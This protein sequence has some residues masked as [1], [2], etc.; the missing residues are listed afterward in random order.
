MGLFSPVRIQDFRYLWVGKIF[1]ELGDWAARLALAALVYE[2]TGSAA[3]TGLVT[4]TIV[5]PWVF[6]PFLVGA[7]A[8]LPYRR[9]MLLTDGIR[10]TAFV[11]LAVGLP[12]PWMIAILLLASLTTPIFDASQAAVIREAVRDDSLYLQARTL[13]HLSSQ[14][15]QLVGLSLGGLLLVLIGPTGALLFNAGTF[16][17]TLVC[18]S[19]LQC[20]RQSNP[21]HGSAVATA[22]LGGRVIMS[23]PYLWRVASAAVLGTAG[24]SAAEALVVAY[25]QAELEKIFIPVLAAVVPATTA[26]TAVLVAKLTRPD[27]TSLLRLAYFTM[28]VGSALAG[29]ALLW[30][31]STAGSVLAFAGAGITFGAMPAMMGITGMRI[32]DNLRAPTFSVLQSS[33]RLSEMLA[34]GVLSLCAAVVG[35][36]L[37]IAI[38]MAFS[39]VTMIAYLARMPK[40]PAAPITDGRVAPRKAPVAV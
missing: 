8:Q 35:V 6:G 26:I 11:A 29:L 40:R 10:F 31:H 33:M 19:L 13:S 30:P 3:L 17:I 36:R 28:I 9:M 32:P 23:D 20:G 12:L 22:R 14:L 2:G 37:A 7:F 1:S 39:L 16:A 25:S 38:G 5:A 21:N 34:V 15:T 4:V 27:E 24:A 18:V